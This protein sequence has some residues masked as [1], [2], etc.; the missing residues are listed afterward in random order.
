MK[1]GCAAEPSGRSKLRFAKRSRQLALARQGVAAGLALSAGREVK[2]AATLTLARAGDTP[3]AKALAEELEKDYPTNTLIRLYGLPTINAA[4]EL[5]K[6]KSSQALVDLEPA[7]PYEL[8]FARTYINYLY[9][10]Y[11]PSQAYLLAHDGNAAAPEFPKLLD[12]PGI[13]LNFVTQALAHLQIAR[14]L[15]MA[16]DTAKARV[17][18]IRTSSISGKT[19]IPTSRSWRKPRPSTRS[20]SCRKSPASLLAV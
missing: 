1:S 16:G 17:A 10:A 5:G 8:G 6:N 19:P 12:H 4:I 7:T 14:A 13:A 20:C 15:A 9:P 3:R 2:I 11:L 18:S